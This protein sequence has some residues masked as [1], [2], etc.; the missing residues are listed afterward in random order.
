MNG[1]PPP[2]ID[3]SKTRQTPSPPPQPQQQ[4]QQQQ[5]QQLISGLYVLVDNIRNQWRTPPEY[6]QLLAS[7]FPS[8]IFLSLFYFY[9]TDG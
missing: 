7:L 4:Q 2:S 9:Y 6:Y 3:D 5:Q 1:T 8:F